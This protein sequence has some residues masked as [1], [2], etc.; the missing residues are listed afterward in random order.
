MGFVWVPE[1]SCPLGLPWDSIASFFTSCLNISQDAVSGSGQGAVMAVSR[2]TCCKQALDEVQHNH[3]G[4][5]RGTFCWEHLCGSSVTLSYFLSSV[6]HMAQL[7][8]RCLILS[9]GQI[10]SATQ[11]IKKNCCLSQNLEI[12]ILSKLLVLMWKK[13]EVKMGKQP[14]RNKQK[15]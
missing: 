11:L 8:F 9:Q 5:W 10:A 15:P 2:G 13:I 6:L 7:P 14:K 12:H 4:A 1:G 3:F